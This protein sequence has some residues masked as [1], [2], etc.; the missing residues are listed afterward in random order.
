MTKFG[1]GV[2]F[3][4]A[5]SCLVQFKNGKHGR[6]N[7]AIQQSEFYQSKAILQI[8]VRWLFLSSIEWTQRNNILGLWPAYQDWTYH[9]EILHCKYDY[10]AC[11]L[12]NQANVVR[13]YWLMLL[14]IKQWQDQSSGEPLSLLSIHWSFLEEDS[15]KRWRNKLLSPFLTARELPAVNE[16]EWGYS[17][18]KRSVQRKWTLALLLLAPSKTTIHHSSSL[19]ISNPPSTDLLLQ[20]LNNKGT[21][22]HSTWY[23]RFRMCR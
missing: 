1:G 15:W 22:I 11:L 10:V 16:Y 20:W 9:R 12:I 6:R 14:H 13:E 8:T 7:F 3:A 4:R 23:M 5:L 17:T 21:L 19:F 2:T 18:E